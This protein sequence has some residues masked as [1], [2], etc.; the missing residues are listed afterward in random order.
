[1]VNKLL[2]QIVKTNCKQIVKIEKCQ[3]YKKIKAQV[4][5]LSFEARKKR[6]T[7]VKPFHTF[8]YP[9]SSYLYIS[10]VNELKYVILARIN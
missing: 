4:L 2:K 1:M 9:R 7:K 8:S 10:K 5:H 3:K 6:S